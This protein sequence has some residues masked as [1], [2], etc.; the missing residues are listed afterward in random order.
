MNRKLL[1]IFGLVGAAL[2][3]YAQTPNLLAVTT[4]GNTTTNSISVRNLE[5]FV[6]TTDPVNQALKSHWLKG[7]PVDPGVV[8]FECTSSAAT[9]GWEFYNSDQNKSLFYIRQATGNVGIGTTDPKVRLAVNGEALAKK[10]RVTPNNWADFVFD[11]SYHLPSLREVERFI[12]QHK[13]LSDIPSAKEVGDSDLELGQNQAKLL[14]KIEEMTLYLI[15]QE[16]VLEEREQ[17][18]KER[19]Q[20]LNDREK[21]LSALEA[22]VGS[23]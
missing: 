7:S 9:A 14:Q 23:E 22:K 20:L 2:T 8:R 12:A 18:I 19:Q 11:S 6:F 1:F 13:H 21:R 17:R 5:G 3:G 15:D 10:V 16:K 4:A